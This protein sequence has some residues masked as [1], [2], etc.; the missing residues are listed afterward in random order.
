M[1]RLLCR[2]AMIA[3]IAL[4][5]VLLASCSS[6]RPAV[7]GIVVGDELA[8]SAIEPGTHLQIHLVDGSVVDDRFVRVNNQVLECELRTFGLDSIQFV[9]RA[10]PTV[11]GFV[12]VLLG[13]AA[14]LLLILGVSG[15]LDFE[16]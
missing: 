11:V 12:F 4:V 8:G 10:G 5:S 7:T 2:S 9:E 16:I 1:I 14:A 6:L 15:A 3:G 13:S